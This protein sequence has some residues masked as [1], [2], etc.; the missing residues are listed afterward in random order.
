MESHSNHDQEDFHFSYTLRRSFQ[1]GDGRLGFTVQ[2]D[3]AAGTMSI[4]DI[5]PGGIADIKNKKLAAAF[6]EAEL[7]LHDEVRKKCVQTNDIIM[8]INGSTDEYWI[9]QELRRGSDIQ[10]LLRRRRPRCEVEDK[11]SFIPGEEHLQSAQREPEIK[12]KPEPPG[13]WYKAIQSFDAASEEQNGYMDL[14]EGYLY[15]VFN[16]TRAAGENNNMHFEYVFAKDKRGSEYGWI[17]WDASWLT[18]VD[19]GIL[20][21]WN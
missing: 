6:D 2:Y 3:R 17:P 10:M 21:Q 8:N 7:S 14:Q 5:V 20:S 1:N 4:L 12:E 11:V 19:H 15:Y 9:T 18:E 16:G 13:K